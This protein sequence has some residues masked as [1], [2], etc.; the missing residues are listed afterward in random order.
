[1]ALD[2]EKLYK[3]I[4]TDL[5]RKK[6][7][8]AGVEVNGDAVLTADWTDLTSADVLHQRGMINS[9]VVDT[10]DGDGTRLTI[11]LIASTVA[12]RVVNHILGY[13]ETPNPD[14][15]P[16]GT[17]GGLDEGGN[18]HEGLRTTGAEAQIIAL[19]D[20]VKEL[21]GKVDQYGNATAGLAGHLQTLMTELASVA[22][23]AALTNSNIVTMLSAEN[24]LH[25]VLGAEVPGTYAAAIATYQ[26][27][28]QSVITSW[29]NIATSHGTFA[30]ATA[31]TIS[32]NFALIEQ[33][34]A[35]I[36]TQINTI[37]STAD[38]TFIA[39]TAVTVE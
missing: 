36:Q 5:A 32:S 26:S 29:T 21:Q 12:D 14:V 11:D 16:A 13:P 35:T 9:D 2:K 22:T 27:T 23:N 39:G 17:G 30:S 37:L 38:T 15:L 33:N 4:Y 31:G 6:N 1:M 3:T 18:V 10:A 24:T 8:V 25:Q 28:M 19:K 34:I 7:L 20:H